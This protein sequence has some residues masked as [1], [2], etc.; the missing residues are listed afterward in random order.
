MLPGAEML[1][2]IARKISGP[3]REVSVYD[4]LLDLRGDGEDRYERALGVAKRWR[5]DAKPS[6]S[7]S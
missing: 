6:H 2:G 5:I 3:V 7:A 1:Y 4:D